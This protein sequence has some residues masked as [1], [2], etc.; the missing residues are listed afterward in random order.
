MFSSLYK[1]SF[2]KIKNLFSFLNFNFNNLK[3]IKEEN[4]VNLNNFFEDS[5]DWFF[6]LIFSPNNSFYDNLN[7]IYLNK[8]GLKD[9]NY[10]HF[11]KNYLKNFYLIGL[12]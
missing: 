10:L 9:L 4:N 2:G 7:N 6:Y 3:E 11:Y 12:I 8:K 5:F 1:P